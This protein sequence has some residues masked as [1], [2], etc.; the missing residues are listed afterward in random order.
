MLRAVLARLRMWLDLLIASR[1]LAAGKPGPAPPAGG[2]SPSGRWS[3]APAAPGAHGTR[4]S[5]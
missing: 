1:D 4:V 3:A 2:G 5:P